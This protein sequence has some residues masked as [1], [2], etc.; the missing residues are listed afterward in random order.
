MLAA[1]LACFLLHNHVLAQSNTACNSSCQQDQ[2]AAV[3]TLFSSISA[4]Q[5]ASTTAA[6]QS[7]AYCAW[8]GVTCCTSNFTLDLSQGF[9]SNVPVSCS[10]PSAISAIL[11]PASGLSGSLPARALPAL[12]Q[13]LAYLD[14]SG[15]QTQVQ[16]VLPGSYSLLVSCCPL[17]DM[18]MQLL[19]CPAPVT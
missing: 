6:M 17:A 11:L 4:S 9:P 18:P 1:L 14:L 19:A 7:P 10:S 12:A 2:L 8:T 5:Q 15:K 3:Q 13:S 16:A